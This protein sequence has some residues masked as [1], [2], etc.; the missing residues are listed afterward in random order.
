MP[1][2]YPLIPVPE[3]DNVTGHFYAIK[4][5]PEVVKH[6]NNARL[7]TDNRGIRLFLIMH[8]LASLLWVKEYLDTHGIKT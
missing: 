8:L 2:G 5:L 7:H 4:V 3:R 1:D 6:Y